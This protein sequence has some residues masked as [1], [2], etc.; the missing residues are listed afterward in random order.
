MATYTLITPT[1]E[2]GPIG[3][4]RLHTHFKQRTKGYTIVNIDGTY[5]LT[6]YPSQDDLE[7]YTAY[8]MGGCIHTGI[9]EAIK[10]EMIAD[11][12]VTESNFTAE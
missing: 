6:Q 4:H 5:S 12:V 9:S 3:G 1:L 7:T 8:Y 11:G 2:Q 10:S